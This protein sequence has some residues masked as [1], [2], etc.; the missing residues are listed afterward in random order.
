VFAPGA[1]ILSTAWTGGYT[2]KDGTSMA[3]PF[4]AGA[5]ALV[6][7][8]HPD[9][10]PAQIKQ[11]LIDSADRRP[12][13]D[14]E[15][16]SGGRLDAAAALRWVASTTFEDDGPPTS[17]PASAPPAEPPAAAPATT[18][19]PPAP[20]T[21]PAPGP[22]PAASVPTAAI[23]RLRLVGKPGRRSA[24]LSFTASAAGSVRFVLER[25][26]GRRYKRAGT[27]TLTV[28][29]GRQRTPLGT[30]IAGVRLKRGTWRLSLAAAR[31]TFRVR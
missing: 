27:G 12:A 2:T 22:A 21:T 30:R 26:T 6:A 25:R 9:W 7:S 19:S 18:P 3:T 29:A 10:T 5:A 4:A 8:A 24:A 13:F 14:G 31:V 11:A 17:P 16:V 1:G 15:S 23:S 28:A 20:Q